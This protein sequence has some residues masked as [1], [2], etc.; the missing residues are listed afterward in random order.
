[1]LAASH[2]IQFVAKEAVMVDACELN[3]QFDKREGQQQG[4]ASA[5]RFT[6]HD[7]IDSGTGG[8]H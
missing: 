6:R 8:F 3:Q 1:M 2:V 7:A 4:H 5:R